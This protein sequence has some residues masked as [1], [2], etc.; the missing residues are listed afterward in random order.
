MEKG[1]VYIRDN[2]EVG[3]PEEVSEAET[4]GGPKRTPDRN[5]A[6]SGITSVGQETEVEYDGYGY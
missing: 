1:D 3:G 5:E 4:T 2:M 6:L